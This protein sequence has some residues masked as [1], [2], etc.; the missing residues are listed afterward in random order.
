MGKV[1]EKMILKGKK[2]QIENKSALIIRNSLW[3][4]ALH[5]LLT[6]ILF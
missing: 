4:T 1:L 2:E 6:L 3:Q 5:K